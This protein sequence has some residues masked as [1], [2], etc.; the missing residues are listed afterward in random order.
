MQRNIKRK[1]CKTGSK[2]CQICNTKEILVEHHIRGR[3]IPNFN[4]NSNLAYVCPNCHQKIHYGI[5]VL[6][7]YFM[8]TS[9][10]EL[11]WHYYKDESF[12]GENIKPHLI[13]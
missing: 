11:F 3:N 2:P 13:K 9:G 4:S 12:T 8:T 10:V 1:I 6:E 7:G 5:I